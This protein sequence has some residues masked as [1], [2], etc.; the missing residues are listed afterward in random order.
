MN[1]IE[2][3][4]GSKEEFYFFLKDEV[5]RLFKG[6]LKIDG[7]RVLIPDNEELDYE[8][9]FVRDE[10]YGDFSIKVKWGQKPEENVH[11]QEDFQEYFQENSKEDSLENFKENSKEDFQEDSEED[12]QENSEEDSKMIIDKHLTMNN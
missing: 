1:S 10:N 5:I 11:F 12:F 4:V 7:T 3:Y 6:K 2:R 9:K 8:F